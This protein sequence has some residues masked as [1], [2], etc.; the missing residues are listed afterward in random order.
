MPDA[1]DVTVQCGHSPRLRQKCRLA[2]LVCGV[3][4]DQPVDERVL[5]KCFGKSESRI[6][7]NSAHDHTDLRG[8]GK[9]LKILHNDAAECVC[10][11]ARLL[12]RPVVHE[13]LRAS[14]P[15]KCIACS[16]GSPPGAHNKARPSHVTRPGNDAHLPSN[17]VANANPIRVISVQFSASHGGAFDDSVDCAD[18]R[19]TRTQLVHCGQHRL[20]QRNRNG[21]SAEIGKR[22]CFRRSGGIV[23]LQKP[24]HVTQSEGGKT[25]V[26]HCRR[27]RMGNWLAKQIILARWSQS[28]QRPKCAEFGNRQLSGCRLEWHEGVCDRREVHICCT[29]QAPTIAHAYGNDGE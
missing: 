9:P 16:P 13:Q 27:V 3:H 2:W 6:R 5:V 23:R 1:V 15:L 29:C 20:L 12:H 18:R 10:K 24:V 22:T 26:V 8:P 7:R 4:N 19:R 11:G 21:S 28:R 14:Q 17:T 25:C